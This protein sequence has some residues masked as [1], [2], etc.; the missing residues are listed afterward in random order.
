M[1]LPLLA[2]AAIAAGSVGYGAYK[3][4]QDDEPIDLGKFAIW[5]RPNVGKT[6]FIQQLLE[7]PISNDKAQTTGKKVWSKEIPIKNVDGKEYKIEEI[8]DMPGTD[9]RFNDWLELAVKCKNIFYIVDLSRWCII[10]NENKYN[11]RVTLDITGTIQEIKDCSGSGARNLNIIFSHID[12]SKWQG[13]P[14]ANIV[15]ELQEEGNIRNIFEEMKDS[16]VAGYGYA[17]NLTDE[18]S[19]KQLINDLI[20]DRNA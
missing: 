7:K 9:D 13:V 20:R 1:P 5:G 6:T 16:G 3:Y 10:D 15:T 4:F 14:L 19:F 8:I 12:K 11:V 2:W 17:V 18:T